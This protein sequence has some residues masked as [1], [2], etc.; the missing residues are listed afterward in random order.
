MATTTKAAVDSNQDEYEETGAAYGDED[1]D[2]GD[3][4]EEESDDYDEEDK[5]FEESRQIVGDEDDEEAEDEEEDE[6]EGEEGAKSGGGGLTH[7]LL[8]S[9]RVPTVEPFLNDLT[10]LFRPMVMPMVMSILKK[11]RRMKT[12]N[13]LKNQHSK[14]LLPLKTRSAGSKSWQ[15]KMTLKNLR[16]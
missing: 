9:V 15:T 13:M 4:A 14:R 7:L 3:N 6:E 8:G 5:D 2:N 10:V 16:E 11:M 12:T 1:L